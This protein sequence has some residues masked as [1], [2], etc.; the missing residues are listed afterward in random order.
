QGDL[1]VTHRFA[2]E[3]K[4]VLLLERPESDLSSPYR[5]LTYRPK[6]GENTHA[7]LAVYSLA[8]DLYGLKGYKGEVHCHTYASDGVQDIP[9]TVGNYRA[10]GYD[11]LAITDH[12]ISFGATQATEMY[13]D[14]SLAMTLLFGE[15][16]HVPEERIHAVHLGGNASVN[17]Y[18]RDHK[19]EVLQ[20]VQDMID[21]LDLPEQVNKTNYA[22]QRWIA[23]KSREMGGIAVLAHPHWIWN[24]VY[25]MAEPLT[26][27]LLKDKVYDTLDL[28]DSHIDVSLALWHEMERQG[29]TIPVVGSTDAHYTYANDPHTP[30]KGG[31]TLAFAPD[32]SAKSLLQAMKQG[33]SLCVF[34]EVSPQLPVGPYR[35]VKYG[36]FLLDYF[37]PYYMW[38]CRAQAPAVSQYSEAQEPLLCQLTQQSEQLIADFY[39]QG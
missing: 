17:Q 31:Y 34:T 22:W 16:V 30:A 1:T 4:H 18:F 27:Q 7:K 6:Y 8:D 26:I 19:Q 38:L 2:G 13:R 9:H 14:S 39:G 10:A 37:F 24:E 32:R 21:T 28:R 20:E 23:E 33:N 3:Q 36:R 29:L 12:Y 5:D 25:F 11:F 35:L 15:E